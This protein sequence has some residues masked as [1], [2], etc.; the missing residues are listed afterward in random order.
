MERS[1]DPHEDLGQKTYR[2][3]TYSDIGLFFLT[4]SVNRHVI[5][6]QYSVESQD[7]SEGM[8]WEGCGRNS[9]GVP[10]SNRETCR[11]EYLLCRIQAESDAL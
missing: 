4:T 1:R 11:L 2:A 9:P 10:E 7:D 5:E 3:T 6:V 8:K